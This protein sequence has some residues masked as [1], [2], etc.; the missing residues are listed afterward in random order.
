MFRIYLGF[1]G[2]YLC[3]AGRGGFGRAGEFG[4]VEILYFR[5]GDGFAGL[6]AVVAYATAN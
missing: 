5:H 6:I 4:L 1:A 3:G 2:T